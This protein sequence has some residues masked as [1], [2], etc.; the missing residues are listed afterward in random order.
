ML[1][2]ENGVF[3]STRSWLFTALNLGQLLCLFTQSLVWITRP[4]CAL[5]STSY[6]LYAVLKKV[7]ETYDSR[8]F[9]TGHPYCIRILSKGTHITWSILILY[10]S[11]LLLHRA[12]L[13]P[14]GTPILYK[15]IS[16]IAWSI[17][18]PYDA[19]IYAMKSA[20]K[21]QTC[22][23]FL[24]LLTITDEIKICFRF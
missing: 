22:Q 10:S 8:R 3:P 21:K 5:L 11:T 7:N 20:V 17:K 1:V 6:S 9:I 4:K 12:F 18:V 19:C 24:C 14:Q 16:P 13:I 23:N 15:H 2:A